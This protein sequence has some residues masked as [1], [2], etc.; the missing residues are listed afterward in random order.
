MAEAADLA[1]SGLLPVFQA[2]QQGRVREVWPFALNLVGQ[3]QPAQQRQ[4]RLPLAQFRIPRQQLQPLEPHQ[5]EQR[6]RAGLVIELGDV[7]LVAPKVFPTA[8]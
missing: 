8:V 2:G 4:P 5:A 1:Q 7:Y 6:P 3:V